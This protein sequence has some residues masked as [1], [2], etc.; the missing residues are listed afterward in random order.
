[1]SPRRVL[2]TGGAGFIGSRLAAQLRA[3]GDEVVVLDDLS[4]GRREKLPEGA[5]LIVGDVRDGAALEAALEGV[6]VVFHLAARVSIRGS[7]EGFR[8]DHDVNLGGTLA[9]LAALP[10][11]A[12]RRVV[13]ASSMAV[14]ADSPDGARVG[15]EHPTR[16]LSPYGVSKL[17][18]EHYLRVMGPRLGVEH[19]SLRYFNTWGPG[20]ELTPY[21]GVATIFVNALLDGRTPTLFGDGAQTRDFVFVDDVARATLRAGEAPLGEPVLNVGTG[22]GTTV[23]ALLEQI[24][25]ALGVPPRAERAPARPEELRHSVADPTRIERSLGV[26]DWAPLDL[27]PLVAHWREHRPPDRR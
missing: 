20:Q 18:S 2:V 12:V 5:R 27:A 9:L 19:V 22:R 26:G 15:E 21:V 10:G 6:E 1:M 13:Y 8:D 16:P 3:R 24:A 14:Y 4:T 11:S 17:A 25:D 23:R 7:I